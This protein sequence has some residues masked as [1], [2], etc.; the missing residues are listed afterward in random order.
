[1]KELL[2]TLAGWERDGVEVGRAVVVRTFGSAPRP[3]GA[4]LL[5]A[6]DGRIAG[7]VS[8]GCVEGAA[9]EEIQHAWTHGHARVI[10]YGI[11]DEQAWDVGLACGGTIDVLVEPVAP[12]A[13]I[14]AAR[15][16]VGA[17]G[18]GTAVVTPL[19]AD[20]P[21]GEF[22]PHQPGTGA[23]PAAELVVSEEGS[24]T[25][26]LGTPDLDAALVS[27]ATEALRRGLS[28]TVE[29][30]GR[31][32]FIEVFPVR[33]RLVMVGGV[34]VARSL[35][36]LA[37]ELGFETVVVDGRAS[38]A[39][40]ER[41]PDVDRLVVG[42]P[43]EV[44]EEIGPRAERRG[45]GPLAR[46][47][48]RRAGDRRGAPPGLSLRRRGRL[49]QDPGGPSGATARSRC[50]RGRPGPAARTGRP[51]PRR[52]GAGRDGAGDPGRDRGRALRRFR[53]PDARA[54]RR[55]RRRRP[56][57]T[58]PPSATAG[59]TGA[60]V[61]AAGAGSRF[62]GGKLVAPL[63]GRPVLQHVLD[64]MDAAG[65]V[66]VVVVLGPDAPVIEAAI[67]WRSE[68]RVVNPDPER[69]LSSSLQVGMAAFADD[70][71][72][73]LIAL[74]DQ[75]LVAVGT[76]RALLDAP[77]DP[78]RPVV[79]PAYAGDLGRNPVLLRRE[80]FP[81]AGEAAGD[82]GLGPVLA[83]HPE[84]VQVIP[85]SGD[86]PD[87][88]TQAD[89]ARAAEAA[90]AARVRAN[91]EQVERVREVPDGADFYAPV[92]SLFRADPT[93]ADDPIL[94]VLLGLV[95][96]G[97][98]WLDVGA[99]AGRFA[100]PIARALD[101]SGGTVVALDASP[102]MLEGLDEIAE[103]YAI[104]NVRAVEARWPPADPGAFDADVVLIAHVGHDIE[105]I[106][107]FLDA[108]ETAARRLCVAILTDQPPASAADPFWLAVHGE[109]RSALPALLDL[110]ELLR[111]RGRDPSVVRVAGEPR[112]FESRDALEGF[113]RRQLWIDPAGGKAGR[114][115][116][117]LEELVVADGEG[118]TI[119]GRVPTDTGVV[120]WHPR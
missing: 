82:R 66:D 112:R 114:L 12:A 61:L 85:I 43:D 23:P 37:R 49:A 80:A 7:S 70:T 17:N 1:M 79:V 52:P 54:G 20:A 9:A 98:R 108:V 101:P 78:S 90:W 110:V 75:P 94:N 34:E 26:T 11:S 96:S 10:R 8:G 120:T 32:L 15:G 74:G 28:R 31:S 115:Q 48:V 45:R 76:I 60:L 2:E 117:A 113:V 25:G 106:G 68:R 16:S 57:L 88:D 116:A 119:R 89:L 58:L 29:L 103:D 41:F 86:N 14:D 81:L 30:G 55:R 65:L 5:Y 47:Q 56:S 21:P 35:V 44:A 64:T 53:R 59:A 105:A 63:A 99:G 46:C 92:R 24:L 36:R 91:R 104:E 95:R 62:G 71:D 84:T 118:W 40:A 50:Q 19:P 73:V 51:G 67:A 87:V 6:K 42:W 39:T 72:A 77:R 22:G 111:A 13:V 100:L 3:E 69:G 4:V 97:E 18:H 93:R 109:V 27:A 38:F 107:A 83:A 33:P 102:S